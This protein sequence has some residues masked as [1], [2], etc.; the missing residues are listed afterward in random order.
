[1]ELVIETLALDAEFA[2]VLSVMQ[3]LAGKKVQVLSKNAPAGL[4]VRGDATRFKQILMNLL[5]NAIKF[6]QNGGRIELGARL[7]G[8]RVFVE[9][10]DNGPGIP[11]DEQKR[12][13]EVFYRLRESGKKTE[14][15]G[16]GL[17]ITHRLV[18][19]HGGDLSL[20]SLVG[21]GSRFYFSLPAGAAAQEPVSHIVEPAPRFVGCP[22]VLVIEDDHATAL[23]L[24]SQLTSAGYEVTLCEQP[25]KATEIAAQLR[26]SAITLDI[27]MRPKNGWEVL[28]QLKRD[29]R[30]AGIP[31]IIVSI[32][33]KAGMGACWG[34]TNIWSNQWIKVVS[35][36][37]WRVTL[38]F[39][40]REI[41][42]GRFW[43]SKMTQRAGSSLPKCS[44]RTVT[45]ST[46]LR[47]V[48]KR[49]LR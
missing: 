39:G 6:T 28:T 35:W 44:V 3:S 37:P 4:A 12:I 47:T 11:P 31:I 18:E 24:Q 25:Q 16:L 8:D 48:R 15:T 30:T 49:A 40:A 42:Q 17:A 7:D 46:R 10:R 2:E 21:E 19:L 20:E 27:V 38:E 22:R 29:P 5:G 1:M 14:G 9:V 41:R 43:S 34:Q 36:L 23:L 33:D 45:P 32:V 13:F 26:P